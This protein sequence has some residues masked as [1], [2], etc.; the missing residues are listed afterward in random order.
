MHFSR[1]LSS[2]GQPKVSLATDFQCLISSPPNSEAAIPT[3]DPIQIDAAIRRCDSRPRRPMGIEPVVV[4]PQPIRPS[5]RLH[6][7]A[8]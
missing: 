7:P 5:I 1:A 3:N 4:F 2:V 8:R 6:I